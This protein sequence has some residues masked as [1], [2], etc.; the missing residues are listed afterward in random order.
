M[1]FE[2]SE[3]EKL[4]TVIFNSKD[5]EIH[6]SLICKNTDIFNRL[7]NSLYNVYPE[8]T[9]SENYFTSNGIRVNKFKL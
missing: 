8:L 6:Y 9:E 2:L 5:E 7:E 4:M 1:S 3:N